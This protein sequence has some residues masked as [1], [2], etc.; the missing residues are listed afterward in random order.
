VVRVKVGVT[1]TTSG[2]SGMPL[3]AAQWRALSST[4]SS[5]RGV[6]PPL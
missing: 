5:Q 1:A 6:F 4:L 2:C 3:A